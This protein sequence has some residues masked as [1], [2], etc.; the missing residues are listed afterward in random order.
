MDNEKGETMKPEFVQC[1]E[2][3]CWTKE[4]W[5]RKEE[6]ERDGR[7]ANPNFGI[8][9]RKSPHHMGVNSQREFSHIYIKAFGKSIHTGI[10]IY[11]QNV[12]VIPNMREDEGCWEGIRKEVDECVTAPTA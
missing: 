2:C 10:M 5:V 11:R 12:R 6:L 8:C 4:H 7:I 9:Q 1:D 3:Q